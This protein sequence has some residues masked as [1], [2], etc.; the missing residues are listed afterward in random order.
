MF[1]VNLWTPQHKCGGL[2]WVDPER[3]FVTPPSKAGFGA[4]EWVNLWT[5]LRQTLRYSPGRDL[6]NSCRFTL[7]LL[8]FLG[9]LRFFS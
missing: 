6:K 7:R 9:T 1:E 8:G 5:L 4:A 3:R 2:L